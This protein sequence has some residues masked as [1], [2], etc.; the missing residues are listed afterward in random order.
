MSTG[1]GKTNVG[2]KL[3]HEKINKIDTD[4]SGNIILQNI[5]GSKITINYNDPEALST[6]LQN[7]TDTQTFELKQ[8]IGSQHKE[9]LTEIRRIQELSDV[10]NTIQKADLI[11]NDLD[12]FFK[13]LAA[14]KIE[15]AKNRILV[16][17]KLL[18]EY[19]E[20]LILEDDPRR[21]MRYQKEME[22][23]RNDIN[24]NELELKNM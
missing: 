12:G 1:T 22:T 16:N 19:E 24:T 17:Y 7:L 23:I 10:K 11:L 20:K 6:V 3:I 18:R 13:E 9:I 21:K 4:G 15:N 2:D 5:N 14:M 8:L